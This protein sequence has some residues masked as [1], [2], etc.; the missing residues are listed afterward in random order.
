MKTLLNPL[1]KCFWKIGKTDLVAFDKQMFTVVWNC[2]G[3]NVKFQQ[4]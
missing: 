4:I 1:N 2:G 3:G